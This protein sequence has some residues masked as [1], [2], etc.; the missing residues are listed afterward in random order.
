MASRVSLVNLQKFTFAPCVD[1]PSMRILAP[2]QKILS[3]PDLMT[4]RADFWMLEAQP[5]NGI[6]ELDVDA[7]VVGIELEL[8]A[9]GARR[10]GRRP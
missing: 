1:L 8:V 3:L 5:L 2:A 6:V 9:A 10:P 4:T 7:E